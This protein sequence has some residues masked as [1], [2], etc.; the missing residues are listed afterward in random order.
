[1]KVTNSCQQLVKSVKWKTSLSL[2]RS[3]RIE[4]VRMDQQSQIPISDLFE[5]HLCVSDLDQAIRFYGTQL[6]LPLAHV[7]PERNVAFFWIGAP[8]KAMLGLWKTATISPG[9]SAHL[10]FEVALDDVHAAPSRLRKAGITPLDL[11]GAPT[12]EPVVLFGC[13]RQPF[14]SAIQITICSSSL[15]Y[16]RFL[17]VLTSKSSHGANGSEPPRPSFEVA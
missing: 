9:S 13:R 5:A 2:R 1:M 12:E 11:A 15:L 3:S 6:G 7:V 4:L 16:C 8:R 17:R 10:A 14:T